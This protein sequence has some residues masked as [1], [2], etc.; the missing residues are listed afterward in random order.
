MNIV[1]DSN[2]L[3]AA[4]RRHT[5]ADVACAAACARL[6]LDAANGETVLEDTRDLI[7]VEYK[8]KC[9]FSGQPG[10]GDRFF[11]WYVRNRWTPARV[12]RVDIGS[13][14]DA[15]IEC[16]PASLRKFDNDD[17]KWIAVYIKG[18]GDRIFNALDSDWAEYAQAMADANVFVSE[19]C[20]QHIKTRETA[21]DGG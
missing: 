17:H 4:N 7:W 14:D 13:D 12:R 9:N 3:V 16:L 8:N 18:S 6:L 1:I 19:L 10:A 20:P 5:H 21:S 2:V 15:V 11:A